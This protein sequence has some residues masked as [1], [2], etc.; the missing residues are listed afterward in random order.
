M[1]LD[2]MVRRY[3]QRAIDHRAPPDRE[4]PAVV[5]VRSAARRTAVSIR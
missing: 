1:I 4:P 5:A 2:V 3:A